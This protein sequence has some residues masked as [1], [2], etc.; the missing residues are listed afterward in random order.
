MTVQP[1]GIGVN[2]HELTAQERSLLSEYPPY[3]VILFARNVD[4]PEQLRSLVADIRATVDP[5]PLI[6]IDEEGGRVDRLRSLVPG[7]PGASAAMEARDPLRF[8][9]DLG[10]TVGDLLRHFGIDVNLAP[11]V[12]IQGDEQ[13]KGLEGRC[14]GQDFES[15]IARSGA[16]IEAMR[17]AGVGACLKHFPGMGRGHADPHHSSSVVDVERDVLLRTDLAPYRALANVTHCV[18]IGHCVYPSIDPDTPASLSE[19]ISTRMLRHELGFTGVAFSDDMEMRAVSDLRSYEKNCELAI[20]AGSDIVLVCK[21]VER[22]PA[23]ARHFDQLEA[24]DESFRRRIIEAH[25]RADGY[26]KHVRRLSIDREPPDLD[27]VVS[28]V[29]QL[30][31]RE[32]TG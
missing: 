11:V 8:A 15:V 28:F 12:D 6:L 7:I 30:G 14:W 31:E 24:N 19:E 3:A 16:F 1:I 10:Q 21:D 23:I 13:P 32:V 22:L 4:S 20:R 29:E 17:R 18:M 25:Q 2:G 9:R 5:S 27:S 26:A